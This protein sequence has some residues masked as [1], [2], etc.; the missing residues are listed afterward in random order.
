MVMVRVGAPSVHGLAL[1]VQDVDLVALRQQLQGPIDRREPNRRPRRSESVVDLLGGEERVSTMENA[2][3]C[4]SLPRRAWSRRQ[5]T[6]LL[7]IERDPLA[8]ALATTNE[9]IAARTIVAPGAT[10]A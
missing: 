2:L 6:V 3:H 10:S 7:P 5:R 4:S 1:N 8:S 9:R